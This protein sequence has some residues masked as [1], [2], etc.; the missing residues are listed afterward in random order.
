MNPLPPFGVVVIGRNEGER[1]VTCIRSVVTFGAPVLYVDSNSTDGS[2]DRAREFGTEVL[3]LDMSRPFTAARA[4]NTGVAAFLRSQPGLRYIQFIDGDCEVVPTWVPAGLEFLESHPDVAVVCGRRR[5]RHPE[6]SVYNLLCD[7][8]WN[9]PVGVTKAC[10][11][12]AM[13]R[14]DALQGVRGFREDLIAGEEPELCVRLRTAGWKVYRLDEEMTLHDA[15]ITRFSQ[16]WRRATRAGYA[17][18]EGASLHGAPPERH[19]V[20]EARSAFLW[21]AA[22]PL[23]TVLSVMAFGPLGMLIALAYP[24]QVVRL[25]FKERGTFFSRG[26]R[27]FF[28]VL[29]KFPEAIGQSK[30]AV[31]RWRGRQV[32]LIEYK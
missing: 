20:R 3:R 7:I 17:F 22:L 32:E 2:R 25:F 24:A 15:N 9:T 14:V 19:W 29:G 28:L 16:W 30:F 1:L 10:G 5:E 23:L 27:A 26:A 4:R 31:R 18:A 11:G 12:D 6:R 21:G 13:V 8:E